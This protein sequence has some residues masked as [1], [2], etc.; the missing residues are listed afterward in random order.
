MVFIKKITI[1]NFKS[2]PRK[3]TIPLSKGFTAITGP[4]GSGKSN[5]IDALCF[6]L[7]KSS[8][9]SMRAYRL[10]ELIYHGNGDSSAYVSLHLDNSEK[11]IPIDSEEIMVSRR[12][13]PEGR[14]VYYLN[15]K[16]ATRTEVVDV[17]SLALLHPDGHNIILQGDV[18]RVI[19]MSPVERRKII[20]EVAGIAEYDEKKEKA[21]KELV[22]VEENLKQVEI[23]LKEV[24]SLLEKLEVEREEA[25]RYK[26][27]SKELD[28]TTAGLF[29]SRLYNENESLDRIKNKITGLN[30]RK[31]SISDE[32]RKIKLYEEEKSKALEEI[33]SKISEMAE[34]ERMDLFKNIE[35]TKGKISYI[36]LLVDQKNKE[37]MSKENEI[38]H[39]NSRTE[40]SLNS[41]KNTETL[42]ENYLKEETD[43]KEKINEKE[44]QI[45]SINE[46]I[47]EK[48]ARGLEIKREIFAINKELEHK[49]DRK[50]IIEKDLDR[51][52]S[53]L[54]RNNNDLGSYEEQRQR[55]EKTFK[56]LEDKIFQ[57]KSRTEKENEEFKRIAYEI[58]SLIN[59][60]KEIKKEIL[61]V[62]KELSDLY[63]DFSRLKSKIKEEEQL[64]GYSKAVREIIRLRDEK[65][66]EGIYG[67]IVE[68]I[69]VDPKYEIAIDVA[70]RGRLNFIVVEDDNVGEKAIKHLKENK[71]GRATFLPLN[72]IKKR[73]YAHK[74]IDA[75]EEGSLGFIVDLVKFDKRFEDAIRYVFGDTLVVE[76]LS[77]AK[78]IG[79]GKVRMVTLDG[80]LIEKGGAMT[81]GFFE[82]RKVSTEKINLKRLIEKI[83]ELKV[84][85]DKLEKDKEVLLENISILERKRND[86]QKESLKSEAEEDETR[87][88]IESLEYKIKKTEDRILQLKDLTG[89]IEREIESKEVILSDLNA[90]IEKLEERK[91]E[92]ESE[93]LYVDENLFNEVKILE[94]DL[95]EL[96]NQKMN[97]LTKLESEKSKLNDVL[98]Q[99][100]SELESRKKTVQEEIRIL[101]EG[102]VEANRELRIHQEKLNEMEEIENKILEGLKDLK[103]ERDLIKSK[104]S[105][106][107]ERKDK[108]NEEIEVINQ[109]ISQLNS[110]KAK[111]ETKI[112][113]LAHQLEK[114]KYQDTV[115]ERSN[116]KELEEK[117]AEIDKELANMGDI[118][119]KSIEDFETT[120]ERNRKLIEQK[121]KLDEEKDA[122]LN[123]MNEIEK[124]K[125]EVFMDAYNEISKNFGDIF[126]FL[127]PD[128]EARL[129]LEDPSNPLESGLLLHARPRDKQLKRIEAL[130]GGEK[131]LT[132]LTFLFSVLKYRPAPF[133]AL[134][135]IDM[136][137]DDENVE[138]IASLIQEYAKDGQ[139]VIVS[140][141]KPMIKLANQL[142]GVTQQKGVSKVVAI[143]F[144]GR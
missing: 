131:T 83:E 2:F 65:I 4:N 107:K 34:R 75:S 37:I 86:L 100:F 111:V 125:L 105:E 118:N 15:Q 20:D 56:E 32:I 120:S 41:I 109:D 73:P 70:G 21:I 24:Q 72:K 33:R 31:N 60:D 14:T 134:D 51:L 101:K 44:L 3:T 67:S 110:N 8:A 9:R 138:K 84:Y 61:R 10:S 143:D 140:L 127:L 80:D 49:I 25:L 77:I 11:S 38:F 89:K 62:E 141:R 96:K 78:K 46:K 94:Q 142:L 135:E 16:R 113:D 121:Q 50:Y 90:D 106:Y 71:I 114:I 19:E 136:F 97:V 133:Y 82:R 119:L 27:L 66:L 81:G 36:T 42:I 12:I 43:L 122:I 124:K 69:E 104:L 64:K 7:G 6:V 40:D 91:R 130:S 108:L 117:I 13:D 74:M 5:I 18:N 28:K 53:A 123:F 48:E 92:I 115:L 79:I 54:E 59:K 132:A 99:R 52:K 17:L 22:K 23:V 137:L 45:K 39:L 55:E 87:V 29:Y 103:E 26:K 129:S 116:I 144:D 112:E 85:K 76:N 47:S 139:F 98:K 30:E 128:G 88:R 35:D 95:I 58:E 63:V 126:S 102:V 93:P 68:L 57:I 1:D